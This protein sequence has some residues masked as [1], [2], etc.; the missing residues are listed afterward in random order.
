MPSEISCALA[1][2]VGVVP[3]SVHR[4]L[5]WLGPL[6]I[7]APCTDA[8]IDITRASASSF[9]P[10][11]V[12]ILW[13]TALENL[14][15]GCKTRFSFPPSPSE[16]STFIQVSGL[17]H[18][19]A[20]GPEPD[21]S[22]G[23]VVPLRQLHQ[24]SWN[25]PT[26]IIDLARRFV[27]LDSDT[28]DFLRICVNEVVQNVED[29]ACSAIG[30]IQSARFRDSP[31]GGQVVE[32]ALVDRGIGIRASLETRYPEIQS[33]ADAISRVLAGGVSARSRQNNMGVG[34]SNL[35]DILLQLGGELIIVSGDTVAYRAPGKALDLPLTFSF[36]GTGVF[37]TI[38]V[39]SAP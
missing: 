28:E 22:I 14:R 7:D 4:L 29:H 8:H 12:T 34:V 30:V 32:V 3:Y 23:E 1:Y 16:I 38:P 2:D 15:R 13:S 9:G 37:F 27:S 26:P 35:H 24:A 20:G 39:K 19:I 10:M 17:N 31:G 18:R 36:A 33:S 6:L 11:A 25:V 21:Q 5:E